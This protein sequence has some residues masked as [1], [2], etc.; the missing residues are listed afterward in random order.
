[1]GKQRHRAI[2]CSV[3][4]Q[5]AVRQDC[6]RHGE[7]LT[8]W[9]TS[10]TPLKGLCLNITDVSVQAHVEQWIDFA[11]TE[12]G[13]PLDSVLYPLLY[14]GHFPYDKKVSHF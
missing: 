9:D 13:S 6:D 10:C 5:G 11:T 14:P 3:G 2:R 7:R 12:V 1:M 8:Q 4:R